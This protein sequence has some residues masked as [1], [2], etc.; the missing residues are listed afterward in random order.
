MRYEDKKRQE[1]LETSDYKWKVT[2]IIQEFLLAERKRATTQYCTWHDWAIAPQ[3]VQF[4]QSISI[5]ILR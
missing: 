1:R 5:Y 4:I 3:F 2:E